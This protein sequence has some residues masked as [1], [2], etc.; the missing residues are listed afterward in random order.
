VDR[1]EE[2]LESV[3]PVLRERE[4]VSEVRGHNIKRRENATVAAAPHHPSKRGR[5]RRPRRR[6]Y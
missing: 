1:Y 5:R 3:R 2:E 6:A 4:T